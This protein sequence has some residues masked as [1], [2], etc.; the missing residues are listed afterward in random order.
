VGVEQRRASTADSTLA[1]AFTCEWCGQDVELVAAETGTELPDVAAFLGK[2]G[3]CLHR[4][5]PRQRRR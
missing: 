4:A 2:H 3:D 5:L 1:V